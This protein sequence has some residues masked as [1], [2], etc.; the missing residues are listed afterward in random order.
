MGVFFSSASSFPPFSLCFQNPYP[1]QA[2][3]RVRRVG[4]SVVFRGGGHEEAVV[5]GRPR[6]A[7]GQQEER[8]RR[9]RRGR[10]RHCCCRRRRRGHCRG[11]RRDDS[12]PRDCGAASQ[13]RGER[14]VRGGGGL[15]GGDGGGEGV[16]VAAALVDVAALVVVVIVVAAAAPAAPAAAARCSRG[17]R[18]RD[19]APAV[20][21]RGLRRAHKER[22]KNNEGRIRRDS[23]FFLSLSLYSTLNKRTIFFALI[24]F[25]TLTHSLTRLRPR[26]AQR[27]PPEA[28]ASAPPGSGT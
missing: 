12:P 14:V 20:A 7:R 8:E 2:N 9:S 19:L 6:G 11:R 22:K 5:A 13:Q 18:S 3:E 15:R 25:F 27:E 26:T 23:S 21:R 24:S 1:D 10:R 17:G 16:C 28:S 4:E